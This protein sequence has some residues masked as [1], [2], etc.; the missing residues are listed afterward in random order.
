M[1][2]KDESNEN[3]IEK[4]L[5]CQHVYYR[6]DGADTIYCRCRNGKCNFKLKEYKEI[7]EGK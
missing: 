2:N 1:N 4:C 7:E 5:K 3:W 6:K